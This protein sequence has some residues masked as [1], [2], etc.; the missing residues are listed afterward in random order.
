M[1]LVR[2]SDPEQ[3]ILMKFVMGHFLPL[4]HFLNLKTCVNLDGKRPIKL[5]NSGSSS[6]RLGFQL[7]IDIL[8][9]NPIELDELSLAILTVERVN[10]LLFNESYGRTLTDWVDRPNDG[11]SNLNLSIIPLYPN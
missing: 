2:Y 8:Q 3:Q 11:L 4:K 1:Q 5:S 9:G 10:P 7:S 6:T